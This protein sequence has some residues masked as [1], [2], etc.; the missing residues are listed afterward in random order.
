MFKMTQILTDTVFKS[1]YLPL[2]AQRRTRAI[3]KYSPP[4]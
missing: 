2:N 4:S 3:L 1:V